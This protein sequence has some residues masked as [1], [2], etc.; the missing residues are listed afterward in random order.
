MAELHEDEWLCWF[1]AYDC[2]I[3]CPNSISFRISYICATRTSA[4]K[5]LSEESF[6]F[7]QTTCASLICRWNHVHH[8][9]LL[10][11]L[12]T[13]D[14]SQ[15]RKK[16][17]LRIYSQLLLDFDNDKSRNCNYCLPFKCLLYYFY[18]SLLGFSQH[19]WD[20]S[21]IDRKLVSTAVQPKTHSV[22][23]FICL[24]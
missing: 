21:I 2:P 17:N 22:H 15:R 24:D 12:K 3:R 14:I 9:Y 8:S 20:D 10:A 19:A 23:D 13:I 18:W 6:F 1:L 16:N 4:R 7:G 11:Y 5:T